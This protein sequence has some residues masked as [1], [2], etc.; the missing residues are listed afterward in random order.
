MAKLDELEKALIDNKENPLGIEGMPEGGPEQLGASGFSS[1]M[2]A[3]LGL[4]SLIAPG[5]K[6][7]KYSK[8]ALEKFL[9]GVGRGADLVL[10]KIQ[11]LQRS[12][13]KGGIS[14]QDFIRGLKGI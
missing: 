1:D 13:A 14:R 7:A 3:L 10:H 8:E 11:T 5:G 12:Y 4:T 9:P 2:L 6:K